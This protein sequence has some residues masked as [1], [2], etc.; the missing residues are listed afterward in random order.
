MS[1]SITSERNKLIDNIFKIDAEQ[2]DINNYQGSTG[3]LDFIELS[4][5][6]TNNIMKGVD[7]NKRKFIVFK[8][9]IILS[10]HKKI[11]TFTTFFQ[12]YSTSD[13]IWYAC[14]DHCLNLFDTTGGATNTQ[15]RLL[16]E[17]L[18]N[19]TIDLSNMEINQIDDLKLS[20][21]YGLN[22]EYK[23]YKNDYPIQINIGYSE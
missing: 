16:Y 17:L 7:I 3:Y 18:S 11:K 14:G 12:R 15:I 6:D 8:A 20:W 1:I 13:S 22:K 9:E 21:K 10:S 2:L 19:K 23:I 5:L 4:S